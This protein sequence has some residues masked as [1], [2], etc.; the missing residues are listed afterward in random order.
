MET[1][2]YRRVISAISSWRDEGNSGCQLLPQTKLSEFGSNASHKLSTVTAST[3]EPN[4]ALALLLDVG[5]TSRVGEIG[6]S[7]IDA[8][9]AIESP[10]AN[11]DR[12]RRAALSPE[13]R[14]CARGGASNHSR[15]VFLKRKIEQQQASNDCDGECW[16]S[17]RGRTGRGREAG[18]VGGEIIGE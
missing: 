2:S 12:S 17:G 4:D 15:Q 3:S 7:S 16:R 9:P 10:S 18:E 8:R 6:F 1:W 13:S 5:R 11:A 14:L